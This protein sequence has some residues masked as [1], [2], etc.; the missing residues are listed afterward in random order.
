VE[1]NAAVHDVSIVDSIG[2]VQSIVVEDDGGYVGVADT[3]REGSAES[4][5]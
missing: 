5:S 2:N 1:L 3:R 4:S